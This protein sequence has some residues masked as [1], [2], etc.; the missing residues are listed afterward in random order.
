MCGRPRRGLLHDSNQG[1]PRTLKKF[2]GLAQPAEKTFRQAEIAR[3]GR[4]A[5][6][7]FCRRGPVFLCQ[8][9]KIFTK[10]LD[11]FMRI[12]YSLATERGETRVLDSTRPTSS[13][14]RPAPAIPNASSVI[15]GSS[16]IRNTT[17]Y[18]EPSGA[19]RPMRTLFHGLE[20]PGSPTPPR[21]QTDGELKKAEVQTNGQSDQW[22]SP[23]FA[24]GA[25]GGMFFCPY[26]AAGRK[27]GQAA[28]M[29]RLTSSFRLSDPAAAC[30]GP[31]GLR[32]AP[33]SG[34]QPFTRDAISSAKFSCFF[35]MPSPFSKRTASLKA[36]VP[37]R[38]LAAEARYFS[39]VMSPSFTK[40]CWSRQFSA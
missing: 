25:D 31:A 37:P 24:D 33:G 38:D 35:S 22:V 16:Q 18:D 6:W 7:W 32:D 8:K 29:S 20:V 12:L 2:W 19:S 11:I 36:I 14:C 39:T 9:R 4:R 26:A 34:D 23:P 3:R 15:S 28:R 17:H 5:I 13:E 40:S 10:G 21:S 30:A 1:V 27:K